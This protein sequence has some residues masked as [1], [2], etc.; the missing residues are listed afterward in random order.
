MKFKLNFFIVQLCKKSERITTD[1]FG[2]VINAYFVSLF[3]VEQRATQSFKMK[4]W[5]YDSFCGV[6]I[7]C[8]NINLPQS[9]SQK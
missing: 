7:I 9:E 6:I 1:I 4:E 5:H 2:Y 8:F 3:S